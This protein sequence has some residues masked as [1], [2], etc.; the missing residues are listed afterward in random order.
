MLSKKLVGGILGIFLLGSATGA[1]AAMPAPAKAVVGAK[2]EGTRK[3]R[4]GKTAPAQV[5]S[6][7]KMTEFVKKI[8]GGFLYTEGGRYSLSGVKM[9]D[10]TSKRK[11]ADLKSL[12][13]RTAEMTFINQQLREIVIRQRQ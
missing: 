5:N 8:E 1:W 2:I 4:E 11:T 9:M 12:P 6:V 3:T 10:F 13:K 7:K